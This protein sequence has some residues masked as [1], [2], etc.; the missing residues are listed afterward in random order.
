M[1]IG[2]GLYSIDDARYA[3]TVSGLTSIGLSIKT[4]RRVKSP[5]VHSMTEAHSDGPWPGSQI[6]VV[7]RHA[8]SFG[9]DEGSGST[10]RLEALQRGF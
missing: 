2:K 4:A 3:D 6:E 8:W 9:T 10:L 5:L 7:A 1:V